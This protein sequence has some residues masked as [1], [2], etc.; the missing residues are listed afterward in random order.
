[1]DFLLDTTTLSHLLKNDEGVSARLDGLGEGDRVYTSVITE[2]ELL[3]GAARAAPA[4]RQQLLATIIP[5]LDRL[6]EVLPV[7]RSVA[8]KYAE[9]S[10][11]LTA[12]GRII[13]VNDLWIA[14]TAAA[15]DFILVAHGEH[16]RRIETLRLEDW[17]E[18]RS[19]R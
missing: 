6:A 14:A 15:G 10:G 2:G 8:S 11:D 16:F 9:F 7:T 18:G 13:P 19:L 5:F 17:L 12:Q 1:M 3:F 4:R